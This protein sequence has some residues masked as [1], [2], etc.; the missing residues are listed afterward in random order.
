MI[1]DIENNTLVTL[2]LEDTIYYLYSNNTKSGVLKEKEY[3]KFK[4]AIAKNTSIREI[5]RSVNLKKK[6]E[7]KYWNISSTITKFVS[8]DENYNYKI[9]V[10]HAIKKIIECFGEYKDLKKINLSVKKLSITERR[11]L[12]QIIKNNKQLTTIKLKGISSIELEAIADAL[13][14]HHNLSTIEL[15][16]NQPLEE[17]SLEKLFSK[18]NTSK[19]LGQFSLLP[20]N[21]INL[22]THEST[23]TQSQV[24][25]N[26]PMISR[27]LAVTLIDQLEENKTLLEL[28]ISYFI[29]SDEDILVSFAF[30]LDKNHSLVSLKYDSSNFEGTNAHQTQINANLKRN[31]TIRNNFLAAVKNNY[32]YTLPSLISEGP[33]LIARDT[34]GYHALHIAASLGYKQSVRYLMLLMLNQEI[35]L[36]LTTPAGLTAL[37]LAKNFKDIHHILSEGIA[38]GPAKLQDYY[39]SVLITEKALKDNLRNIDQYIITLQSQLSDSKSKLQLQIDEAS[40]RQAQLE[41]SDEEIKQDLYKLNT[42]L[43]ELNYEEKAITE[44]SRSPNHLIYYQTLKIKIEEIFLSAKAALGGY[45]KLSD[46]KLGTARMLLE[47]FGDGVSLLP[48]IGNVIEKISKWFILKPIEKL[49][50]HNLKSKLS[51]LSAK[52]TMSDIPKLSTRLAAELTRRYHDQI[53]LLASIEEQEQYERTNSNAARRIAQQ[54]ASAFV[55]IRKQSAAGKL[56]NYSITVL[57][58]ILNGNIQIESNKTLDEFLLSEILKTQS[59]PRNNS[60]WNEIKQDLIKINPM[61]KNTMTIL[62][63]TSSGHF[64]SEPYMVY[65][66]CGVKIENAISG[67]DYYVRDHTVGDSIPLCLPNRYKFRIGSPQE[68]AALKLCK[69]SNEAIAAGSSNVATV[70]PSNLTDAELNQPPITPQEIDDINTKVTDLTN[71]ISSFISQQQYLDLNSTLTE[72]ETKVQMLE[73]WV[74]NRTA[75]AFFRPL[76][77]TP[78]A[79][80]NS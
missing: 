47:L 13:E 58:E 34:N 22:N 65:S 21:E 53:S 63:K 44:F 54:A 6:F 29:V 25:H 12:A 52:L 68:I 33:S 20:A 40:S 35:S 5:T 45:V 69:A 4:L 24:K 60:L 55:E 31:V 48:G 76:P 72:L 27:D 42:T 15:I 71:R 19:S 62:I 11:D 67:W 43:Q 16:A 79:N 14:T 77:A 46:G 26:K 64:L 41:K 1:A 78:R 57:C 39:D 3:K 18:L 38:E 9:V 36:E 56:A 23:N 66:L 61:Y 28:D 30:M 10:I 37:D 17:S 7:E 80:N 70:A 51:T 2:S 50:E 75:P 59:L 73:R 74:A 49:D 32:I 8:G